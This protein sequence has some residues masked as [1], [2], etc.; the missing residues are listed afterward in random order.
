MSCGHCSC[1]G[2]RNA[3]M[4]MHAAEED[5]EHIR[6][7]R[8]CAPRPR[9]SP[10][11]CSHCSFSGDLM[12]AVSPASGSLPKSGESRVAPSD[13]QAQHGVW[14]TV[15]K[16]CKQGVKLILDSLLCSPLPA[17]SLH[18]ASFLI[19]REGSGGFPWG[20]PACGLLW[21][22]GRRTGPLPRAAQDHERSPTCSRWQRG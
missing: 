14:Q 8:Q 19:C 22:W 13:P 6:G 21:D 7:Q 17:T 2:D 9:A 3:H 15:G 18:T 11:V 4:A 10:A 20:L 5:R 12:N 1:R 16:I